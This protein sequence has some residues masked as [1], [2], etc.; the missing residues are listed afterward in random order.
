ME[1]QNSS[2]AEG[3]AKLAISNSWELSW[4]NHPQLTILADT[5]QGGDRG[6]ARTGV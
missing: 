2:K 3:W 5:E 1:G 4:D 6:V